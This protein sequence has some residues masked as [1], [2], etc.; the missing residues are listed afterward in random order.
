MACEQRVKGE[1][2]GQGREKGTESKVCNHKC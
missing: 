1:G 2:I